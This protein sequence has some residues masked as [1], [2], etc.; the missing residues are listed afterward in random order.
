MS[1]P[2]PPRAPSAGMTS[3][4]SDAAGGISP[5]QL[6]RRARSTCP[7][8]STRWI[9]AG[10]PT[11]FGAG[12][13][14]RRD[15]AWTP[16]R[17]HTLARM[18]DRGLG[19]PITMPDG[20]SGRQ[21]PAFVGGC[22]MANSAAPS[23]FVG[24]LARPPC[25]PRP[26]RPERRREDHPAPAVSPGS[27]AP[28]GGGRRLCRPPRP[29]ATRRADHKPGRR[30]PL[31]PVA[32]GPPLPRWRRH[33]CAH[34]PLPGGGRGLY[35]TGRGRPPVPGKAPASPAAARWRGGGSGSRRRTRLSGTDGEVG[36]VRVLVGRGRPTGIAASEEG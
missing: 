7:D 12:T 17:R 16:T 19:S 25:P 34:Q 30:G 9:V 32:G 20:S 23:V 5:M 2:N 10:Q 8:T 18:D 29:G 26:A 27:E 28:A 6:V 24:N 35:G 1:C 36:E 33:R 15:V 11:L 21:S 14:L 31:C 13:R 22:G 3:S 4:R